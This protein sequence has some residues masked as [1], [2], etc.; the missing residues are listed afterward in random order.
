MKVYA[1]IRSDGRVLTVS[2]LRNHTTS[3][4]VEISDADVL[5]IFSDLE[6]HYWDGSKVVHRPI[7]TDVTDYYG[8]LGRFIQA[9][10]H[11]EAT[12]HG[13]L[14][15]FSG[16]TNK[17]ARALFSGTRAEAAKQYITRIADAT[18]LDSEVKADLKYVFDQL[19]VIN[20][21][22]NDIVHY[23]TNF[24]GDQFIVSNEYLA[25]L[26]TRVRKI[27]VSSEILNQMTSDLNKITAHLIVRITGTSDPGTSGSLRKCLIPILQRPWLYKPKPP[28]PPE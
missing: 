22:R 23:G 5:V 2:P 1:E 13:A 19:G 12:M 25:H 18:D 24:G 27:E 17:V 15:E 16:V 7:P 8:S 11:T 6:P 9:F 10:A 28:T 20:S 21:T 3:K 14:R 26:P 4:W